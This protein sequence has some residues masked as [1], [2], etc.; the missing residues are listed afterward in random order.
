MTDL[1]NFEKAEY[2]AGSGTS[3]AL[4]E[5]CV[6]CRQPLTQHFFR[7]NGQ[8]LCELCADAAVAS[9]RG[10]DA[11]FLTAMIYGVGAAILGC[12]LYA[13]VEIATGWTIGYVAL[14]V[15]WLIGKG[16]KR[17]SS[18]RGGRR[19]QFV[20]VGLTYFS[21]SSASLV[22][23]LYGLRGHEIRISEQLVFRM[24]E[25]IALSPFL[26]LRTGLSGIIGLFILFIGMQAA[27]SMAAGSEYQI[28]GPHSAIPA[29]IPAETPH[30]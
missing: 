16:M 13:V 30:A 25:Y 15:G 12:I 1:P 21:V 23:I 17:G 20:A 14:A 24:I 27:W 3:A 11:A 10:A 29:A 7:L 28:T 19:Y 2:G 9:P 4:A 26:S 8:P 22:V 6:R 18:G 5:R